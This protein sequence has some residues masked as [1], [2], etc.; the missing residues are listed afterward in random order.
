VEACNF[1]EKM[2]QL[3]VED[4]LPPSAFINYD[5]FTLISI[6]STTGVPHRVP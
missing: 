6:C 1:T 2:K 5:F 3:L 4:E